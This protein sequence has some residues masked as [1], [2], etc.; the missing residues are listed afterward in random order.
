M[1]TGIV[2]SSQEV[3]PV[4]S[5]I[6]RICLFSL[7]VCVLC[8]KAEAAEPRPPV[9]LMRR[10]ILLT[11]PGG[12]AKVQQWVA[13]EREGRRK[14]RPN[15]TGDTNRAARIARILGQQDDTRAA[16]ET[17][18]PAQLQA[19]GEAIF[20]EALVKRLQEKFRAF[21]LP[22][23]EVQAALKAQGWTPTDAAKPENALRLCAT[24]ES[25]AL[26]SVSP[27]KVRVRETR[28]REVTFQISLRLPVL[29]AMPSE[30]KGVGYRVSGVG[31]FPNGAPSADNT[32]EPE[33]QEGAD[34]RHPT[35][36]TQHPALQFRV[37]G[38]AS[39]GRI[40]FRTEF[41]N[42]RRNLVR[43]AARLAAA[44]AAHTLWT[45]E[46]DPLEHEGVR[47]AL[48]PIPVPSV[49]DKL[50]FTAQGRQ[51]LPGAVRLLLA[52]GA[53][54]FAPDLSPLTGEAIITPKRTGD[55]LRQMGITPEQLWTRE[56][57]PNIQLL[58]SL[59]QKLKADY[60]L[61]ARVVSLEVR[62]APVAG[63]TSE[64][65]R[66]IEAQAEAVGSLVRVS[67]GVILWQ[68]RANANMVERV[69]P[70][71]NGK[72]N[73]TETRIAQ[74]AV[75]FALLQLQRRFRGFRH[76]FAQ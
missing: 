58:R 42:S 34:S 31:E 19:F 59:G 16:A 46:T 29:R 38:K 47:L 74:M 15:A 67:D 25:D 27:A 72:T 5:Q 33:K 3:L 11:P 43:D 44:R 53:A 22:D 4:R 18:T 21:L 9:F 60:L 14:P 40:L 62:D 26:L 20:A 1:P 68:E 76:H 54:L 32:N 2:N 56:G 37:T 69:R 63:G 64:I 61:L 52:D 6:A 65:A 10:V 48:T 66:E 36:D 57:M 73:V 23:K 75:R 24:L 70:D 41:A 50:Q 39:V 55:I 28:T 71:A 30:E 12:D 13:Q 35:P 49:A 7:L 45:G 17:A 51:A 8:G